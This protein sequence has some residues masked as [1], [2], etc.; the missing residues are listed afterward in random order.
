MTGIWLDWKRNRIVPFKQTKRGNSSFSEV[1]EVKRIISES[2][3]HAKFM[4]HLYSESLSP[5]SIDGPCYV[6]MLYATSKKVLDSAIGWNGPFC[7]IPKKV[8]TFFFFDLRILNG[9]AINLYFS[10]RIAW[11][12]YPFYK[13]ET[14]RRHSR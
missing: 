10:I 1:P 11:K 8:Y 4:N 3:A 7:D 13:Y 12:K 14:G 9:V 6:G 2:G 5:N